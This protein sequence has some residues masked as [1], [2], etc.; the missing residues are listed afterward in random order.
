MAWKLVQT[1]PVIVT[2]TS[3]RRREIV[4]A[5]RAERLP[6]IIRMRGMRDDSV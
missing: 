3:N 6:D 5:T 2:G 1:R 4:L